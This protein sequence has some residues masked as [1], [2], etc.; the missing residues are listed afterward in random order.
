MVHLI[1]LLKS[2]HGQELNLCARLE[3]AEGLFGEVRWDSF[4]NILTQ[5]LVA[6][7]PPSTEQCLLMYLVL[8]YFIL[9]LTT[10]FLWGRKAIGSGHA[11]FASS[12]PLCCIHGKWNFLFIYFAASF[13]VQC[14]HLWAN[15]WTKWTMLSCFHRSIF[16]FSVKLG[17]IHSEMIESTKNSELVAATA[18]QYSV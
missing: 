14:W 5:G 1:W 11:I 16:Y 13:C 7:N 17:I 9:H 8:N 3:P 15:F 18:G 6:V 10:F 2:T 12:K 4:K